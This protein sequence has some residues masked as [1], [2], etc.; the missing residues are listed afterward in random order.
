MLEINLTIVIVLS[1]LSAAL[2]L[3]YRKLATRWQIID[4]PNARSLHQIPTIRGGGL[5]FISLWFLIGI[6]I[7]NRYGSDPAWSWLLAAIGMVAGISFIDDVKSLRARTRF[8]IHLIASTLVAIAIWPSHSFTWAVM[9]IMGVWAINHFN[10]MDGMDGFA[11]SQAITVLVPYAAISY[12]LL[13]IIDYWLAL[14]LA[15]VLLG[16]LVWNFPR[17]KIFMGDVG[18]AT[19]GLI[20]WILGLRID[21]SGQTWLMLNG[22]FLFDA[23]ITLARRILNG[24]KW[25][26]AHRSHLYQRLHQAGIS[27]RRLLLGQFLVNLVIIGL[28]VFSLYHPGYT[29]GMMVLEFSFLSALYLAGE[30]V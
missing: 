6:V 20:L 27:V 9:I 12:Q 21:H 14:T 5:V 26:E 1:A 4:N 19:L 10:F 7:L 3:I 13:H 23:S 29:V 18:S 24:E 25:Y 8:L 16:F 15:S 28:W 2:L 17:A 30:Y 11:T 22:L